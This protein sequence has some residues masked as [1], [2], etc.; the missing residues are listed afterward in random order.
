MN[1]ELT[2]D[3]LE[4]HRQDCITY[5]EADLSVAAQVDEAQIKDQM[6]LRFA[7]TFS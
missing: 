6:V 7:K 2:I 3:D 5:Y 1:P 4:Q